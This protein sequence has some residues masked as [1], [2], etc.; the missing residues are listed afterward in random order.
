MARTS[1]IIRY[2]GRIG[3]PVVHAA[4]NGRRFIMVRA[5]G[6]GVKR[7]YEGSLYTDNGKTMALRLG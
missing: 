6:C 1:R 2:H 3:Y 7:L 5:K 4:K